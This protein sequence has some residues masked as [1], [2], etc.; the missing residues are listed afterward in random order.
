M[1]FHG[2]RGALS[3]ALHRASRQ[4]STL[5]H[6]WPR[7]PRAAVMLAFL[8]LVILPTAIARPDP[9]AAAPGAQ[10]NVKRGIYG[11]G[12]NI[13]SKGNLRVGVDNRYVS[14]RFRA[15]TTSELIAV[16]WQVRLGPVYS[17]GD[18]GIARI[19]IQTDNGYGVPSGTVLASL[20]YSPGRGP[21]AGVLRRMTFPAP[22]QITAGRIYHV[23]FENVHPNPGSNWYSVNELYTAGNYTPRQPALRRAYAVLRNGGSGWQVDQRH[24]AGMSL[25]YANGVQDGLAYIGVLLDHYGLIGGSRLVRERITVSGRDRAI[26]QAYVRVGRQHGGGSLNIRLE[27]GSGELIAQGTVAASSIPYWP[28]GGNGMNGDWVGVR[29]G[30]THILNAGRTYNLVLSAPSGTQFSMIPVHHT[31]DNTSDQHGGARLNSWAF[32]DGNGQS[33]RD[34]GSS[35]AALYR[36]STVNIQFYLR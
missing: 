25:T 3:R 2:L 33:S 15:S 32:R 21:T 4:R 22:P 8:L 35:W 1:F 17:G 27:T 12:I 30:K 20:R 13:D 24:T 16:T 14:H 28:L 10:S 6:P 9:V 5:E 36:W 26:S 31:Q 7:I 18:G 29:F 19:T 11:V 23:V 34:G